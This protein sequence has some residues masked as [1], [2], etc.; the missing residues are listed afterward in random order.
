MKI[1]QILVLITLLLLINKITYSQNNE[2][3][4]DV[5]YNDYK[6]KLFAKFQEGNKFATDSASEINMDAIFH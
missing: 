2:I 6:V 5:I 1:R 4:S 3:I